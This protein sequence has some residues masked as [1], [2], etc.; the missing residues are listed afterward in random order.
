M[1]PAR[2]LLT[3]AAGLVGHWPRRTRPDTVTLWP[4]VHRRPLPDAHSVTADLRSSDEAVRVVSQAQP[5]MVI[6]AAYARDQESVVDLTQ[7]VAVAAASVGA[8]FIYISTDAVF[9]GDGVP[10]AEGDT[11]DPIWDYGSWKAEAEDVVTRTVA[12]AAVVRLPLVVSLDPEDN[13][14]RRIRDAAANGEAVQW[15][16]DEF[17][18]P[19][20]GED[21]AHALWRVAALPRHARTGVWHLPGPETLSRLDIA[22]RVATRLGLDLPGNTGTMTPASANRPRHLHLLCDRAQREIAWAP[23]KILG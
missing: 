6:H 8:A 3:G 15:F 12:D 4:L 1:T 13:A 17:R 20:N 2:V 22:L 19:A 23:T 14:V 16:H 21:I 5:D 11:P 10:R 9:S 18:Q 7:N